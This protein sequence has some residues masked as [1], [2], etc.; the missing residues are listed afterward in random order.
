MGRAHNP[1]Q[2]VRFIDFRNDGYKRSNRKTRDKSINL[3]DMDDA[4][5]RYAELIDLALHGRAYL[6]IFTKE[7]YVEDT[8]DPQSGADWNFEQHKKIDTSPTEADFRKTVADYM[9]WEVDQLL[10][11]GWAPDNDSKTGKLYPHLTLQFWRKRLN[12]ASFGL[13]ICLKSLTQKR[14]LMPIH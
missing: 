6:N 2:I 12:G 9:A 14:S 13:G 10:K 1:K 4:K 3:R 7:E 5:G 8:I 11:T